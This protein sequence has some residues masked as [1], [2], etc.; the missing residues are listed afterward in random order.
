MFA[1]VI[2]KKK[3]NERFFSLRTRA[4]KKESGKSENCGTG[5]EKKRHYFNLP[6]L[7]VRRANCFLWKVISGRLS[8]GNILPTV[9]TAVYLFLAFPF[10]FLDA[11]LSPIDATRRFNVS[12]LSLVIDASSISLEYHTVHSSRKNRAEHF[13]NGTVGS[14]AVRND[15]NL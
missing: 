4:G 13:N 10:I 8:R 6:P 2:E 3:K 1:N 15:Q 14:R 5:W 11:V 9:F 12:P 7:F